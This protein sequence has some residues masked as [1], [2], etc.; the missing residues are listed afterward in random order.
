MYTYGEQGHAEPERYEV[1]ID[2]EEK[3]LLELAMRFLW[4]SGSNEINPDQ[5]YNKRRT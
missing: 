3:E 2:A 4:R 1:K 5:R